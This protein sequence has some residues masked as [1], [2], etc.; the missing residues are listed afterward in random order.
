MTARPFFRFRISATAAAAAALLLVPLSSSA[1]AP[2]IALM[3]KQ[4]V[5]ESVTSMVKDALLGSLRGMGCKGIALSNAI[6]ALDVRGGG[7]RMA[8]PSIAGMAG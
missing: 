1:L 8:L 2:A 5:Q 4:M 7:A 3:V 6:T